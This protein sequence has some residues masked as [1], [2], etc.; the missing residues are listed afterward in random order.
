MAALVLLRITVGWH[1]LYEGLWKYEQ[2]NFTADNFLSRASGPL[3]DLYQD[4]IVKDF[5]WRKAL[6]KDWNLEE[7]DRYYNRFLS[8]VQLDDAGRNLA[9]RALAARKQNV[10]QTLDNADNNKLLQEYFRQWDQLREKRDLLNSGKG[11][12]SFDR[13]R[14]WEAQQ[15]LRAEARPY[16][17]PLEAQ[18]EGL[19]EDLMRTL[20]PEQRDR[21]IRPQWGEI[22]KDNDLL[23]TYL[24]IA[25]GACLILG[26]FSRLAALGGGLFLA[27][28]VAATWQWP[29]YYSPPLHPAQGHSLFVTKEFVEMMACFALAAIPTGRWGGLDFFIHYGLV[30][31]LLVEKD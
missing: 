14:L 31:P 17:A 26:L 4:K 10:A 2:D 3:A 13:E 27:I 21:K 28:I 8:Q 7:L 22:V 9:E 24:N 20:P 6:N 16:L 11:D 15:K 12:T 1:I 29:G 30:R 5:E 18:H 23:V 25:I 19:R